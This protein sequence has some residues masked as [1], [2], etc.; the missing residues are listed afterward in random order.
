MHAGGKLVEL[1]D[2]VMEGG[3]EDMLE[4]GEDPDERLLH[5]VHSGEQVHRLPQLMRVR[6]LHQLQTISDTYGVK[7]LIYS[8]L[9][10]LFII[11]SALGDFRC[12][13][14]ATDNVLINTTCYPQKDI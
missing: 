11:L 7:A 5:V 4:A 8:V 9:L 10:T 3:C 12:I 1:T 2:I 13:P 14:T 6:L